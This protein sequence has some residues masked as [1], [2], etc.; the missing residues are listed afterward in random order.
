L[1]SICAFSIL[2]K[3]I[4]S[5]TFTLFPLKYLFNKNIQPLITLKIPIKPPIIKPRHS[6]HFCKAKTYNSSSFY[7]LLQ[8]S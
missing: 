1:N 4:P 3:A 7:F 8:N 6:F 2:I 5:L